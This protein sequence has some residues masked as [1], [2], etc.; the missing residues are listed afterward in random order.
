MVNDT[1]MYR[2][3]PMPYGGVKASGIGREG[4]RY[5]IEEMTGLKIVVFNL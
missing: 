3:D 1:S 4:P 5:T 2:V